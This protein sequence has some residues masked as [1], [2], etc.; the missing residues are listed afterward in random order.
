MTRSVHIVLWSLATMTLLAVDPIIGISFDKG[1]Q[2]DFGGTDSNVTVV[3]GLQGATGMT[4]ELRVRNQAA[5]NKTLA[6]QARG[7]GL[8]GKGFPVGRQS[9]GS[10][11]SLIYRPLPRLSAREGAVSMWVKPETWRGDDKAE[12]RHFFSARQ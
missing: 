10:I 2:A 4:A 6:D 8:V 1:V 7:D 11:Y 12:F 5:E 9:D 3:A